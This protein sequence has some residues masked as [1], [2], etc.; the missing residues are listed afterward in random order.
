MK[1]VWKDVK[2]YNGLYKVSNKGRVMSLSRTVRCKGN[3]FRTIRQ[4]I[5]KQEMNRLGYCLVSLHKGL[6]QYSEKVRRLVG[7]AFIENPNNY[8]E[9]NHKDENPSNNSVENL[10]WCDHLYNSKYGTRGRKISKANL[11]NILT[12]L[13]VVQ[14]TKDGKLVNEFPS[15]QEASRSTGIANGSICW[16]CKGKLLSAGG[17]VWNYK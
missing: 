5:L 1:E 10:E 14:Y 8:A 15:I 12:S 3:S 17:F 2:G 11:N 13:P 6:K 4:R 9:I 7:I 16:A